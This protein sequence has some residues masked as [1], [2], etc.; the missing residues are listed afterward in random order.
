MLHKAQLLMSLSLPCTQ[1]IDSIFNGLYDQGLANWS[2]LQKLWKYP[3]QQVGEGLGGE[4][5][6][7][8]TQS[9]LCCWPFLSTSIY[10]R[11]HQL[12]DWPPS[13]EWTQALSP[14]QIPAEEAQLLYW[15]HD[16]RILQ[17]TQMSR[18][19]FKMVRIKVDWIWLN[20][21]L[22]VFDYRAFNWRTNEDRSFIHYRGSHHQTLHRITSPD[23]IC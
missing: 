2:A 12:G 10:Q 1:P 13:Q 8:R 3:A 16:V 22:S 14:N 15:N 19:L 6:Y 7:F 18:D 21:S 23:W 11:S 9:P 5:G 17:A 20:L 4:M